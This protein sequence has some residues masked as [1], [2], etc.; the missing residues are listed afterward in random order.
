MEDHHVI[1]LYLRC[2]DGLDSD[3]NGPVVISA[4]VT[5]TACDLVDACT[6]FLTSDTTVTILFS[7]YLAILVIYS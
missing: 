4:S 1:C 6:S 2:R 7:G 5:L 3:T